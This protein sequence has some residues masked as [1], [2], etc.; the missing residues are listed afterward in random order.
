M[1]TTPSSDSLPRFD[2]WETLEKLGEGG[3]C[4]VYRVRPATGT[5]PERAVKVLMDRS[6]TSIRRFADEGLLLQRMDHPNI[7]EVH[8]IAGDARPP[9]LVMDLLAGRDLEETIEVEGAMDPERAARMFADLADAL[10]TVHAA[11]IRHR[12]IKPAN[13][14]LGTDGVPRLIDFGIARDASAERHTKQGFVVG[15]ASYLP[16]EIFLDEDAHGVQD[17]EV[18]DVYALGQ[19]LCEVLAGRVTH[20]HREEGTEAS[21]LVRIMRDKMEREHLDPRER[22]GHV[23]EEL[24]AIV[25]RATARSAADRTPTARKLEQ[26]LRT[27]VQSRESF[28]NA[29]PIS[30]VDLPRPHQNLPAVVPAVVPPPPP[31]RRSRLGLW[32]GALGAMG[33]AGVGV[34]VVG[35]AALAILG[36]VGLWVF[37]PKGSADEAGI[38]DT[39]A[40]LEGELSACRSGTGELRVSLTVRNGR[41]ERVD[42]ARSTVDRRTEKCVVRALTRAHYPAGAS[43]TVEVPVVFR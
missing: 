13:V 20:G 28:G 31:V 43:A 3:M 16:P 40:S 37:R 10:A 12:D 4:E 15:T 30:R 32:F 35:L 1:A 8:Q 9:W 5:G 25:R 27:W 11:G 42:V 34:V 38:L 2:G 36:A 14:R 23:P 6:D 7:V 24:A 21:L 33:M 22:G 41:A 19:T 39:V 29:A 18:A 26:E 17:T